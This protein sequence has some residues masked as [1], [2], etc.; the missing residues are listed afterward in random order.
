VVA[1]KA[2]HK[3]GWIDIYYRRLTTRESPWTPLLETKSPNAINASP[4]WSRNG[5]HIVFRSN[6]N[7]PIELFRISVNP[8]SGQISANMDQIEQILD[9]KKLPKRLNST[10]IALSDWGIPSA[11]N[12]AEGQGDILFSIPADP[13]GYDL[14]RLPANAT[15][16]EEV[17][18]GKNAQ[19]HGAFS[20]NNRFIAYS[21]NDMRD[22][23]RHEVYV[24]PYPDL[25]PGRLKVSENTLQALGGSEPE[26]SVNGSEL[27]YLSEGRD[28][29]AAPIR[30]GKPGEPELLFQTQAPQAINALRT[31][32]AASRNGSFL[33][34]VVT[35]AVT[36]PSITVFTNWLDHLK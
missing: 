36:P 28:L 7:G 26:W 3:K 4:I 8:S 21:S 34:N 16:A 27:Y 6:L 30:E 11:T 1:T 5:R 12:S 19:I 18:P 17:L 33:I 32:Y 29:M 2:N 25:K 13:N 10:S 15:E 23:R 22:E 24:S 35:P 14:W 9:S 31:N 20:P